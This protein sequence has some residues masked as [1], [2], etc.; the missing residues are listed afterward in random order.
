MTVWYH[1]TTILKRRFAL[2]TAGL[3]GL[4][5]AIITTLIFGYATYAEAGIN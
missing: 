3:I 1:I 5:V 2:Q 4:C